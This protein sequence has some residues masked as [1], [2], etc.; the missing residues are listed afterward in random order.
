[1]C[2]LNC[3][4]TAFVDAVFLLVGGIVM[5]SLGSAWLLSTGAWSPMW[6]VLLNWNHEYYNWS[7]ENI[8]YKVRLVSAYFPPFSL[9]HFAAVPL[10]LVAIFR[11]DPARAILAALYLGWLLQA[12]I[13]QKEFDYAHAPPTLL[14]LAVLAAYRWPVGQVFFAWCLLAGLANHFLGERET[15]VRW[16]AEHPKTMGVVVPHHPIAR[17]DRFGALAAVFSR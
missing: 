10:A 5:G 6:D 12:T 1:M 17:A 9:L 3:V 16:Q 13:V 8:F 2:V 11:R 14:G 4:A 15:F 7:R